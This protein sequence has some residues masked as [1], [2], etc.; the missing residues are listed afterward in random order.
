M[1]VRYDPEVDA[2]YVRLRNGRVI[3]F[4]EIEPGLI[5]DFDGEER[6]VGVEILNVKG[7]LEHRPRRSRTTRNV[8]PINS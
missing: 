2:M 1:K 8:K 7:K 3:E 6:V 5:V 4:Q